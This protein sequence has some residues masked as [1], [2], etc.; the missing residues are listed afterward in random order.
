MEIAVLVDEKGNTS[1]MEKSGILR[2]YSVDNGHWTE[3]KHMEYELKLIDNANQLRDTIRFMI[4]WLET[5]KILVVRRIRGIHY[6]AFEEGQVSVLEISGKP[7]EFLDDIKEC[8]QHQRRGREVPLE[9]SG[10]FEMQPGSFY[11]DLREVMNGNTS[12]NSKQILLPFLKNRSFNTL[13][14]ICGHIPKWLEKDARELGLVMAV[15]K[16]NDC[17]KVKVYRNKNKG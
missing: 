2:V 17:V 3:K 15:E 13:E 8:L 14:M 10:I 11:T 7:E 16:Y 12:Y 6:I 1:V 9:Y 5:C 4:D